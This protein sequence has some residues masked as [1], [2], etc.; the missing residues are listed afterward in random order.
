MLRN[1]LFERFSHQFLTFPAVIE[2][3]SSKNSATKKTVFQITEE[4]ICAFCDTT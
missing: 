3:S 4:E 1:W 2:I